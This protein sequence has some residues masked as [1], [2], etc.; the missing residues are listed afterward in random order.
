MGTPA[1]DG[2]RGR[3]FMAELVGT[4]VFVLGALSAVALARNRRV[5]VS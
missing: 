3:V 4:A 2:R 5:V 1:C